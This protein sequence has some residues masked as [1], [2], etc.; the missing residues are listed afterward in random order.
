MALSK[1]MAKEISRRI[2][3]MNSYVILV[4]AALKSEDYAKA[5]SAMEWHNQEADALIAMG[6]E[7]AKYGDGGRNST[8]IGN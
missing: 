2:N 5:R 6:I 4:D 8:L 1:K 3:G 7:V